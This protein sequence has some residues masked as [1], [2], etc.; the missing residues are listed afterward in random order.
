MTSVNS[1]RFCALAFVSRSGMIHPNS[2]KA[3]K[4]S[5]LHTSYNHC[6]D[7]LDVD[8]IFSRCFYKVASHLSCQLNAFLVGNLPFS[9]G[10]IAFIANMDNGIAEPHV[11]L[12]GSWGRYDGQPRWRLD[13][14][15]EQWRR[16]SVI[17]CRSACYYI[18]SLQCTSELAMAI[19]VQS[20]W[21]YR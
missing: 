21:T 4:V 1:A 7:L 5:L 10:Q 2:N 6:E 9:S 14:R 20:K 12:A 15:S 13:R 16:H 18:Q 3:L 19:D 8:T 11:S 17:T